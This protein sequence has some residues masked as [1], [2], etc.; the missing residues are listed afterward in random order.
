MKKNLIKLNLKDLQL[1][2]GKGLTSNYK[3][4][5]DKETHC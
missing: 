5:K 4:H 1:K 2:I 3:K